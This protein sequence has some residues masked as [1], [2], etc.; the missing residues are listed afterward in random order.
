M[1]AWSPASKPLR[2]PI[3]R[4][5]LELLHEGLDP[6]VLLHACVLSAADRGFWGQVHLR[7]FFAATEQKFDP[8]WVPKVLDLGI[9]SAVDGS[10]GLHLFYTKTKWY[11]GEDITLVRQCSSSN[12]IA[13]LSNHLTMNDVPFH[14]PLFS[15]RVGLSWCF[16]TKRCFLCI[17]NN[18]WSG[19][20]IP[21]TT[22]HSFCIGSTT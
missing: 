8:R 14:L 12:P 19:S 13:S 18:I 15:F 21:H 22:G 10:R 6:L 11:V 2:P 16:L 9:A 7:E 5:M 4:C 20:G 1:D 17:C 3:T